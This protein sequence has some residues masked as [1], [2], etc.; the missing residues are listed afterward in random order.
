MLQ[1]CVGGKRRATATD[2]Q[3]SSVQLRFVK[4]LLLHVRL[5]LLDALLPLLV[6]FVVALSVV[7]QPVA[8][9]ALAASTTASRRRRR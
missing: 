4:T 1:G 8:A 6:T 5:E 2:L 9:L 3:L 7:T